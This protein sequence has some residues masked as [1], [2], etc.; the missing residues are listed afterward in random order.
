MAPFSVR[1]SR[2]DDMLAFHM[3]E[4]EFIA[5][6][7]ALVQGDSTGVPLELRTL[8]LR[9]IAAQLGDR[10]RSSVVISAI[11]AGGQGGMMSVLLHKSINDVVQQAAA[12]GY[13][14]AGVDAPAAA[15]AAGAAAAGGGAGSSSG[16]G[17]GAAAGAGAGGVQG[18]SSSGG[19]YNVAFVDALLALVGALVSSTSGCSALADAGVI[20]SLLPLISDGHPEHVGLVSSSVRILEAYMDFSQPACTLF[21]DLDGLRFLIARLAHE[22][23]ALGSRKEG[24]AAAVAGSSAGL[25]G[26]SGAGGEAVATGASGGATT[27]AAGPSAA[28]AGSSGA[29]GSTTSSGGKQ[30]GNECWLLSNKLSGVCAQFLRQHV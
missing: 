15:T 9:C 8:G 17:S 10:T 11:T 21:R 6:L 2:A 22:V 26:S 20:T 12:L 16:G 3:A 30:V 28:A 7:V 25:G 5:D 13:T 27:A 19:E 29:S 18:S 23:G 14:V 4:P 24:A 1:A